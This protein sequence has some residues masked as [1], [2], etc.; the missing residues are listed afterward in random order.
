MAQS[1]A[2]SRGQL[3]PG[4]G[5]PPLPHGHAWRNKFSFSHYVYTILV[6]NFLNG[7][8][9]VNEL[10]CDSNSVYQQK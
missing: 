2:G 8:C 1:A 3:R 5:F 9:D 4:E 6:L 7:G 10:L